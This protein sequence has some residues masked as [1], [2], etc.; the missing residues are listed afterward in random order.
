MT[1]CLRL[2]PEAQPDW[3]LLATA[4][5]TNV[6]IWTQDRHLFGAG[7]P[8]WTTKALGRVLGVLSA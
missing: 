4:L 5:A 3:F 7:V 6:A 2:E 1:R 8:T